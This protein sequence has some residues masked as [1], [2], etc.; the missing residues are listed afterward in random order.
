MK[1]LDFSFCL[2]FFVIYSL[3][4]TSMVVMA[5]QID[6]S[7]YHEITISEGDTLWELAVKYE[8]HHQMSEHEFVNWVSNVNGIEKS[9]ITPGQQI[10]IP[11]K[12]EQVA[13]LEKELK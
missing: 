13:L 8:G 11:V 3:V 5:D 6:V 9:H 7:D 4:I 1:K 12:I 2:V 10:L